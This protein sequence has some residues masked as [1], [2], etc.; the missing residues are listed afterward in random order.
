MLC[1]KEGFSGP[2][3][4]A[5]YSTILYATAVPSCSSALSVQ[6]NH[7]AEMYM[8]IW[9]SLAVSLLCAL[10]FF[11]RCFYSSKAGGALLCATHAVAADDLDA[12]SWPNADATLDSSTQR[13]AHFIPAREAA[14]CCPAANHFMGQITR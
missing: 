6:T 12:T 8:T 1:T 10:F 2:V 4:G 9:K 7:I 5:R 11:S 13:L 3:L 14:S